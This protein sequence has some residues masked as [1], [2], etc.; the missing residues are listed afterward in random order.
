MKSLLVRL[1]SL[2]SKPNRDVRETNAHMRR[3]LGGGK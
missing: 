1:L 2:L 3:V